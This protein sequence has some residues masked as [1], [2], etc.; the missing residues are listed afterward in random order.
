MRTSNRHYTIT[1][2]MGFT[3]GVSCSG[4]ESLPAHTFDA[5]ENFVLTHRGGDRADAGELLS[6]SAKRNIGK[7]ISARNYVGVITMTDGTVIEILPKIAREGISIEDTKKI[8]LKMLKTL[9]DVSFKDFNL[10]HLHVERLNLLEIF[11]RMFVNEISILTKQGLK[12]AY[13]LMEDNLPFLKG[14]MLIAD[15]I[16]F[17]VVNKDRFYVIYDEFSLNRPENRLIKLT[18]ERVMSLTRDGYNKL[19]TSRLLSYF[20]SVTSSNNIEADFSKCTNDRSVNHYAQALKWCRVFLKHKG[21]TPY[22]GREVAL[23]LLFPMEKIFESYV[24]S[25]VREQAGGDVRVKTQDSRFSLFDDPQPAFSLRPDIVIEKEDQT[26]VIDT[27]WKLLSERKRNLDISQADM[28]QMY[29]YGKKYDADRVVLVYPR[30]EAVPEGSVWY[31]SNDGVS[32]QVFFVDLE[33]AKSSIHGLMT[34]EVIL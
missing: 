31:A 18:L 34:S 2:Y 20:E 10:S 30:S 12:S 5:L 32:V 23:A 6:L 28:Y 24:A 22:A 26:I 8:F 1:E 29:A 21:F 7:V 3:R 14:K 27:K 11:I 25:I 19:N 13:R 16:R 17:N 33:D 15:N 9:R 4:Y